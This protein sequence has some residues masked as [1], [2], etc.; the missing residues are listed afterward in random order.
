MPLTA[1]KHRRNRRRE[2]ASTPPSAAN[3]T[4]TATK[5]TNDV[6]L[7]FDQPVAYM[8]GTPLLT[9]ATRTFVSAVQTGPAQIT[10][11]FNG[12]VA[13]LAWEQGELDPS[14]RTNSGGFVRA[15][16]GTFP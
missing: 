4:L 12:T 13:T 14:M 8:G 16:C 5:S 10:V 6:I 7:D 2:Q 3:A 15:A 9:V 11:T 1:N